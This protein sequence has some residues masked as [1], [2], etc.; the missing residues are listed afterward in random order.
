[1]LNTGSLFFGVILAAVDVLMETLC[2]YYSV[3][4]NGNAKPL[5]FLLAAV[6][7]N[8]LQPLIFTKALQTEGMTII[9]IMWDTI[10]TVFIVILGLFAFKEKINR[11]QAA[12][13]ILS[14]FCILLLSYSEGGKKL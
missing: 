12:G 6:A 13:I 5:K 8:A 10:S 9:N 14:I 2:K 11:Y 4:L 3:N 1:M 7:I